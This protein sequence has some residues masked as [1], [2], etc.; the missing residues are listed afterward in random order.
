MSKKGISTD[1]YTYHVNSL[2]E[3]CR[4]ALKEWDTR[5]AARTKY[6]GRF[7]Q[8]I[9][10]LPDIPTGY[11]SREAVLSDRITDD[12][13]LSPR[14]V[15]RAV[16]SECREL[17]SD[18]DRFLKLVELCRHTVVITKEQNDSSDIKIRTKP[19]LYVPG[20]TIEKYDRFGWYKEGEGFLTATINGQTIFKPFP[21][22][23]MVPDWLTHFE[24][25]II[26]N[27]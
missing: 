16:M 6:S 19:K 20:L 22:K 3:E 2:F 11:M 27:N 25:K 21:L 5:E 24:K 8:T 1:D 13:F 26:A 23:H 14:L 4:I 15:F 9:Y 18:Y 17:L 7:Y 10:G 12:H